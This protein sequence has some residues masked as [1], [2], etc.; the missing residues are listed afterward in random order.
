[1]RSLLRNRENPERIDKTLDRPF[2]DATHC[3]DTIHRVGENG[4]EQ[5]LRVDRQTAQ[6][7]RWVDDTGTLETGSRAMP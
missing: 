3:D 2:A 5:D 4:I 7:R 6:A 1:L